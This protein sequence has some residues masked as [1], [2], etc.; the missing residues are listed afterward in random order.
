MSRPLSIAVEDV[1]TVFRS[2]VPDRCAV[3][4]AAPI[5]TGREFYNRKREFGKALHN[6]E[7][8]L[9]QHVVE[10]NRNRVRPLIAHL[11][12][13]INK[14]LID[15]T[16]LE[17]HGWKQADYR[18]LWRRVIEMFVEEIVFLNG[19]EYS[20][21]CVHEFLVACGQQLKMFTQD[22]TPMTVTEGRRLVELA[23]GDLRRSGH[24]CSAHTYALDQLGAI[25]RDA[26]RS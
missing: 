14:P 13:K 5:T 19:W 22:L 26:R 11:R 24:D 17:L 3:Y 16:L 10:P 9:T 15:P 25:A 23:S 1:L 4:V 21:G 7:A 6:Y 12:E 18:Q 20:T 2:I 8:L